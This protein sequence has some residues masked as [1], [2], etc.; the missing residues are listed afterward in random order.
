M[1]PSPRDF[2]SDFVKPTY[3]SRRLT[4]KFPIGRREVLLIEWKWRSR[5]LSSFVRRKPASVRRSIV[6]RRH[7]PRHRRTSGAMGGRRLRK[8]TSAST[9]AT[10][11]G[12]WCPT[13]WAPTFRWWGPWRRSKRGLR[14]RGARERQPSISTTAEVAA[15]ASCLSC[16]CDLRT[17][18]KTL[19]RLLWALPVCAR[20]HQQFE[21][22]TGDYE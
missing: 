12:R 7:V 8:K 21:S 13:R 9:P 5:V 17:E 6:G 1:R 2:T 22:L 14:W 10:S 4:C 3:W 19:K 11:S 20:D 16:L 18:Q 15:R